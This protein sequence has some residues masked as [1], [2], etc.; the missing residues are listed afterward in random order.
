MDKAR[1]G[2]PKVHNEYLIILILI[3]HTVG[4]ERGG[5]G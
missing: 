5:R 4:Y 3:L 1:E 2:L